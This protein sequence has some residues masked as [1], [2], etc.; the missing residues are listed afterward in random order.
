[1]LRKRGRT[2]ELASDPGA[3]KVHDMNDSPGGNNSNPTP[4]VNP[5]ADNESNA[6]SIEPG[7]K[8]TNNKRGCHGHATEEECK[9]QDTLRIRS[10]E[11]GR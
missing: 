1:M 4:S 5:E 3:L 2:E 7:I 11:A 8:L 6:T 9:R 10:R